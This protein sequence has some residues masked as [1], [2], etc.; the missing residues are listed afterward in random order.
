M[1]ASMADAELP[2]Q[3]V[4]AAEKS[5]A[6]G[7]LA[8]N[9][10]KELVREQLIS[11]AAEIFNTK[12]YAQTSMSDIANALG[13]G[14]SALYHYFRNKEEIFGTLMEEEALIPYNALLKLAEEK[15]L[16][17]TQ[18]LRRAVVDGIVRRLSAGA[19]FLVVS[20]MES[21][22]PPEI[23]PVYNSSKRKILDLYTGFIQDGV[24]SGEFRD[25][26]PKLAAFAVI[27]MANSASRWFHPT[28]SKSPKEIADFIAEIA[29]RGLLSDGAERRDARIASEAL[30][31]AI[32]QLRGGLDALEKLAR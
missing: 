20:S 15:G 14:R 21:E 8:P 16:S 10:R 5:P 22:I 24:R 12:G 25:V 29:I 11:I 3:A 13:L 19:R 7:R 23:A 32:Q 31:D 6:N 1:K 26:D 30:G 9:P 18:R 4:S 2:K 27:G 17:A 28:G